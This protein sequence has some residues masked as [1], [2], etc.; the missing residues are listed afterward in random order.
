MAAKG[1]SRR[2]N[3][4]SLHSVEQAS[5]F[6]SRMIDKLFEIMGSK[7]GQTLKEH[8]ELV[9]SDFARS[10][11]FIMS[12]HGFGPKRAAALANA[13]EGSIRSIEQLESI[14]ER[15]D[16]THAQKLGIRYYCDSQ[17]RIPR[18]EMHR[19]VHLLRQS[20]QQVDNDL[21]MMVCGS[22]RRELDTSGDVDCLLSWSSIDVA[23][24]RPSN[25]SR[26]PMADLVSVLDHRG[27]I[28]GMLGHGATKVM[29]FAQ[30]ENGLPVRRLDIRWVA[31]ESF[32]TAMLY[33]TGSAEFNSRMRGAALQKGFT[34]NEY[35]L[36]HLVDGKRAAGPTPSSRGGKR[37]PVS[38]ER[39]VFDAIDFP[40]VEPRDRR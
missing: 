13:Y 29:A 1:T 32:P 8:Q 4:T 34:L 10:A 33:F 17:L 12:V 3:P 36:F 19:H 20:C 11:R 35:G 9:N 38:S 25:E 30:L 37:V 26:G 39:E 22:Y 27:Y 15:E 5:G 31:P 6:G 14:A 23:A 28:K 18:A 16:F 2:S 21:A 7:D 40:Y 24:A